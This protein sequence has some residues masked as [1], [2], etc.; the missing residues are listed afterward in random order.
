MPWDIDVV[1][2]PAMMGYKRKSDEIAS[3]NNLSKWWKQS[4]TRIKNEFQNHL[5]EWVLPTYMDNPYR[6]AE[7]HFT[8][9]RTNGKGIDSDAL[10]PSTY[11]WAIDVLTHQ[12]YIIDDD[13]CRVVLNPTELHVPGLIETQVRM[14]IKL[15]E[16]FTMTVTELRDAVA[17]LQIELQTRVGEGQ[18]VKAASANVRKILGEIKN[19]TPQLRRDL[20]ELDKK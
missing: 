6:W 5:K 9:L 4:K 14:Q 15:K 11:K 18:H 16:Q 10:G 8:I 20:V 2:V 19:A 1:F 17:T 12:G 3:T 7:I 13:K